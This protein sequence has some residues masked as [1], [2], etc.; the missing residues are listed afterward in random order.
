MRVSVPL[1]GFSRTDVSPNPRPRAVAWGG[2]VWESLIPLGLT[3]LFDRDRWPARVGVRFFTGLCLVAN[4]AYLGLG[5]TMPAGDAA[6]LVR[7][8]TPVWVLI[9]FGAIATT[10]GLYLWHQCRRLRDVITPRPAP[11]VAGLASGS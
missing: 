9:T 11:A 6:D 5:W 2:P 10:M 1:V 3:F 4:G 7:L 8:G